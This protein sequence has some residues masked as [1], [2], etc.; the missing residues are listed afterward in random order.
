MGY[1]LV[2]PRFCRLARALGAQGY[3]ITT[4]AQAAKIV[5]EAISTNGAVVIEV[6][7]DVRQTIDRSLVAASG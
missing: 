2:Q 3:T 5:A 6:R 7:S 1:G 4:A